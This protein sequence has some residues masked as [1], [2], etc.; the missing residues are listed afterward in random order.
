MGMPGLMITAELYA[1]VCKR[2]TSTAT[3]RCFCHSETWRHTY[4]PAP[5]LCPQY[6]H[7]AGII[8]RVS[9]PS[10]RKPTLA[11]EFKNFSFYLARNQETPR[12]E[13]CLSLSLPRAD[14]FCCFCVCGRTISL[15][16]QPGKNSALTGPMSRLP[17]V[18][19]ACLE[20]LEWNTPFS[21]S[22]NAA[23]CAI[24]EEQSDQ[25]YQ[26]TQW[27]CVPWKRSSRPLWRHKSHFYQLVRTAQTSWDCLVFVPYQTCRSSDKASVLTGI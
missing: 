21:S 26:S 2:R 18:L 1:I 6:I 12:R 14:T 11:L 8:H 3:Q 25:I 19:A 20:L 24:S 7:K 4:T 23:T 10:Q 13:S 16:I 15:I 22:T 5:S 27:T 9:A 17:D